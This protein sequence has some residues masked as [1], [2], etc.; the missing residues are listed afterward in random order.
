MK[1]R[2]NENLYQTLGV[3][4][5]E[6]SAFMSE[7]LSD[8]GNEDYAELGM[9]LG[10]MRAVSILHQ[11]NHWL[12]KGQDYYESHL[13][14]ERLYD[15]TSGDIDGLAERTIG[16]GNATVIDY[17]KQ[18]HTMEKF[19]NLIENYSPTAE[20]NVAKRY[21]LKSLYAELFF[22]KMGEIVMDML[23]QER[24]LTRGLEQTLGNILDKHESLV[25][26]LKQSMGMSG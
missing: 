1:Q 18:L 25:Y 19:L 17:F 10:T 2:L 15:T 4:K 13:L 23:E 5:Q 8:L 21:L 16:L 6:L 26:L 3:D 9:L 24:L 7:V 20:L 11:T 12:V 22:I 14:F